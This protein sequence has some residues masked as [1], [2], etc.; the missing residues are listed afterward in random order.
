[1]EAIKWAINT[2][3]TKFQILSD[4]QASIYALSNLF[5]TIP[6]IATIH[7]LISQN[8][9]KLIYLTWIKGHA[10]ITGNELA[11]AC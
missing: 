10:G 5:P 11:S 4:S 8:P 3:Y 1:M 7:T 9:Q 2:S 6:E